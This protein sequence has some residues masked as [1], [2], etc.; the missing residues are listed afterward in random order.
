MVT[1][2]GGVDRLIRERTKT[3]AN[4][5]DHVPKEKDAPFDVEIL[6]TDLCVDRAIKKSGKKG[7]GLGNTEHMLQCRLKKLMIIKIA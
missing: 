4:N 6:G 3:L 5:D 2:Q 7:F 1:V